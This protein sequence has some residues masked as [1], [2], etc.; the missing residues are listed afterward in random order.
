MTDAINATCINCGNEAFFSREPF[1]PP[2]AVSI[3]T[4][5]CDLCDDGDFEMTFYYDADGKEIMSSQSKD[6]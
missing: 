3:K 5:L 2:D 1:D 4:S 6:D